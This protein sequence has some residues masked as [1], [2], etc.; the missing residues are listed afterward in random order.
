MGNQSKTVEPY[1]SYYIR[2]FG[3]T[4]FKGAGFL[5]HILKHYV[6]SVQPG[7]A[8]D[9]KRL[10]EKAAAEQGVTPDALHRSVRRYIADGWE[11]GL[12]RKWR[13]YTGWSGDTPPDTGTAIQLLCKSFFGFM[14]DNDKNLKDV[15]SP[16]DDVLAES[17]LCMTL[18]D[19]K[20][21]DAYV[22]YLT[23]R[24]Q[25]DLY[26]LC[27]ES[28]EL[29]GT[30]WKEFVWEMRSRER[31]RQAAAAVARETIEEFRSKSRFNFGVE[32][33]TLPPDGG[34]IRSARLFSVEE[35]RAQVESILLTAE[36]VQYKRQLARG[37]A[38][39]WE[40]FL[41]EMAQDQSL[42]RETLMA[43]R[44]ALISLDFKPRWQSE[45]LEGLR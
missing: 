40:Y 32:N 36:I 20:E 23:Y 28:G 11:Q 2:Q 33:V 42:W 29:G 39:S 6:T 13:E 12:S 31:L 9:Y 10:I 14:K 41:A 8:T 34:H 45:Q 38:Y 35:G 15:I 30:S 21:L 1:I 26:E 18:E 19:K 17:H 27:R 44:N 37:K 43:F 24:V 16:G 5:S 22:C 4:S 3:R 7:E 25:R